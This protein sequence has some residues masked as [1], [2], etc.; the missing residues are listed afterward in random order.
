MSSRTILAVLGGFCL[1]GCAELLPPT[2][3]TPVR[4]TQAAPMPRSPAIAPPPVALPIQAELADLIAH[5]PFF[6]LPTGNFV[7]FKTRAAMNIGGQTM[8]VTTS[9]VRVPDSPLARWSK[10]IFFDDKQNQPTKMES[11]GWAGLIN[12]SSH[13]SEISMNGYKS[14][15]VQATRLDKLTGQP[16]PLKA[17]NVFGWEVTDKG[18]GWIQDPNKHEPF[19][20]SITRYKCTVGTTGPAS[21]IQA[22]IPGSATALTC[23]ESFNNGP[24]QTRIFHWFDRVGSFVQDKNP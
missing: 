20:M 1:F 11:L 14:F 8:D 16:F 23:S 5:S 12:L 6:K 3:D 10:D 15:T 2:D 22:D 24:E 4:A 7:P 19:I 21:A 18:S 13:T 17:G 9:I